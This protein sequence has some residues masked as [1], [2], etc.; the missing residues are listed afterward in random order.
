MVSAGPG[1]TAWTARRDQGR[2]AR[3][4]RPGR[5][6]HAPPRR[7]RRRRGAG[8]RPAADRRRGPLPVAGQAPR[9]G[10]RRRRS[11]RC[12]ASPTSSST[13]GPRAG[14]ARRRRAPSEIRAAHPHLVVTVA[15]AVRPRRPARR[16]PGDRTSSSFANGGIMSITG[17]R[18]RPPLQTGGDQA[19]MLG[20]LHAF[21]A[22]VDGAVRGARAGRGRPARHLAAGVRGVDARVLRRGVG[23]REPARR[24]QRQHAAGRVGRVPGGRRLGRRVLPRAPAAGAVRR[25]SASSTRRASWTRCSAPSTSD[26]LMAHVLVFMVERTKDELVA[27]RAG[28]QAADR[29]RAHARRAGRARAADRARVLRRRTRT[30]ACPA[31]RSRASAGRRCGPVA[32]GRRRR[33]A[34]RAGAA[35]RA[36]GAVVKQLP[37]DGRP[38]PRPDHDVGR[39][40]R[41]EDARRDGRRGDQD[42]VAPGVGQ[43]PHADAAQPTSST[44]RGTRRSTSPSTTTRSGRSRSTWPQPAGQGRLPAAG[45]QQRRRHRE[46]PRRR[47]GQ[48]RADDGRPASAP[49][50]TWCSSAWPGFGKTGGDA[51]QRRLR[52]DHRDDVGPDVAVGLR[53]RRAAQDRHLLRRPGR[54]ARRRSGAIALGADQAAADRARV[55]R[56]PVAVR[57]VV[58]DGRRRVRRAASLRARCRRPP[59]NR[60]PRWA[61]Q[62]CYPVRGDDQWIVVSCTDDAEWAACAERHR[63]PRPRRRC[64]STSGEPATTSSTRSIGAWSA[65]LDATGG[66]RRAA[67]GRRAG[68]AGARHAHAQGRPPPLR[69]RLLGPGAQREDAPVPQARRGVAAARGEPDDHPPRPVPRRR[70]PRRPDRGRRADRRRDRPAR[71]RRASSPTRSAT[72]SYG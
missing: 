48:P 33:R 66:R 10:R 16:P 70:Q 12:S 20:G 28:E 47:D 45:R 51:G 41:H 34:R 72:I 69:P 24:A 4:R 17:E 2:G 30:G 44:I 32:D 67:G 61:P 9:R 64:R 42:R 35:S 63:P 3:R 56:R 25:C 62:G 65:P 54:R 58:E 57:G 15:H 11:T 39:S 23:V 59:G 21:A 40:V 55:G 52:A 14:A 27:A 6:L 49:S 37:L 18:D 7:L 38:G 5:V 29:R 68:R 46:L 8:R 26:E 43:H 19:L 71:G 53:A 60:Q 13:V 50:P 1:A 22:T 36:G 31:G